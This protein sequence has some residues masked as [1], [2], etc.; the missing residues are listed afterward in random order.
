MT[1][2]IVTDSTATLSP[3]LVQQHDIHIIPLK[4]I[5]GQ[6][7]YRDGID[8]APEEFYR[9]VEQNKELPT[10]SQPSVGEF[11]ALYRRLAESYD[12]IV[13]I[14]ISSKL[15]GTVG[16]AQS[17]LTQFDAVPVRVVDSLSTAMGLGFV[18]LAAARK[19]VAGG[20]LDT[21]AEV[22]EQV[23]KRMQVHLMPR[24]MDYLRW[25]GRIGTATA[26]LG[27]LLRIQPILYVDNGLTAALEK[28]R[29]RKRALRRLVETVA[30]RLGE[31]AGPVHAA[32]QAV[33]NPEELAT[34]AALTKDILRPV[35]FYTSDLSLVVGVHV[36]PG[37]LGVIAYREP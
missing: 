37:T 4:V 31:G 25:G 36:G 32:V 27:T 21:V 24:T 29:G 2:A 8:I 1:V 13:S 14:H 3:E 23:K 5:F 20:D 26:F 35:E 28:A 19:A 22:A 17:A 15:S 30:E 9:R 11:V 33:N 6:E 7:S 12:S 34:V 18:A 16:A 10:T